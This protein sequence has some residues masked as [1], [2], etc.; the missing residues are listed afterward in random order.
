MTTGM[1]VIS[2]ANLVSD[3]QKGNSEVRVQR[4]KWSSDTRWDPVKRQE[5]ATLQFCQLVFKSAMRS[6]LRSPLPS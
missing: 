5:E 2:W 1:I 3:L 4:E 6:P